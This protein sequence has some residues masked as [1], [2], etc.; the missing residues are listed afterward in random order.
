[1]L[2]AAKAESEGGWRGVGRESN[3]SKRMRDREKERKGNASI[4]LRKVKMSH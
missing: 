1:M 2:S 3:D 4:R